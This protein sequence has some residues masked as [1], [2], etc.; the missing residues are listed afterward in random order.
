MSSKEWSKTKRGSGI[1]SGNITENAH[2]HDASVLYIPYCSSDSFSGNQ[3]NS[4]LGWHFMGSAIVMSAIEE[5]LGNLGL[6]SAS[7]VIFT[8]SSAGAEGLY[9]NADRVALMLGQ[10]V[11][12]RVLLDSAWFL[13][14]DPFYQG[15]CKVVTSCTEQEGLRRGALHWNPRMDDDCAAHK[16][17]SLL[18]QCILG[19]HAFPYLKVPS[20]VFAY[21]Y[22]AA[23]LGH[24]GIYS[25]PSTPQQIAYAN[26][27]AKNI[28]LSFGW[29]GVTA[30]FNPSCY[31]HTIE[32]DGNW[33]KLLINGKS[34]ADVAYAWTLDPTST[35]KYQ[36]T[37]LGA[38]CNPTCSKL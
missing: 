35:P 21:S 12:F 20:F 7:Q 38:N 8:G 32:L 36:D 3:M 18:W 9:P 4:D 15:D 6:K 17:A 29:A 28:S 30:F 22:D 26:E 24:S 23:G 2:W 25:K 37:C 19:Y 13:D 27:V 14:F 1:L 11:N 33:N 10:H 16:S 34:F 31:F 5:A